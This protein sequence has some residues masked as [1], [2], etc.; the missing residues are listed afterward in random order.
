MSKSKWLS[1]WGAA[2]SYTEFRA[3]EYAKDVTLRY[4]IRTAAGGNKLRLWLSNYCGTEAVA[5]T[6]IIVSTSSGGNTA[7][8]TRNVTVTLNGS[9]RITLAAGEERFT[10]AVDFKVAAGEEIA[11][12]IY[13][14]DF[15][16]MQC[17]QWL[18]GPVARYFVCKGDHAADRELPVELTVGTIDVCYLCGI[19]LLTDENARAVITY[20]DSITAQAWPERLMQLYFDS[21]EKTCVVRRAVGGSRVLHRYLCETYRHYGLSGRERFEREIEAASGADTVLILHGINDIIHP[22]PSGS[23]PF[24]PMS[25]FPTAAG[26]IAGLTDYVE[27]AHRHGLK[28]LL[29]TLTPFKGWS[30]YAGFR[31]EVRHELNAWI[32]SNDIA[33]GYIDFDAAVRDELDSDRYAPPYDSVDHLHPNYEAT[34]AMA[35][36]AF[37]ALKK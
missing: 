26:L 8:P 10:D 33:D 22:D 3:A 30:T 27:T 25:D 35:K 24:R 1:V 23:N 9:E 18:Q 20:G 17:G 12:S 36:T 29:C 28:V 34:A 15:T 4:I 6:R 7:D 5:F 32:R 11:V 13:L 21:G 19:D 37:A 31:E 2:P 16:S 14:G